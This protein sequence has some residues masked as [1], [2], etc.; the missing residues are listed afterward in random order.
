ME[1]GEGKITQLPTERHSKLQSSFLPIFFANCLEQREIIRL[2]E[3]QK[4]QFPE[5]SPS[6]VRAWEKLLDASLEGF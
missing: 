4:G 2:R 5:T 6:P 3:S 1:D